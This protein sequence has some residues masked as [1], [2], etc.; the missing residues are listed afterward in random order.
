MPVV[1]GGAERGGRSGSEQNPDA[2]AGK[3]WSGKAGKGDGSGTQSQ[4]REGSEE[5]QEL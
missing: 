3:L 4:S 1:D 2:W 5:R